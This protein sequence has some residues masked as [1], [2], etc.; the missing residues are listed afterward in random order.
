MMG[1]LTQYKKMKFAKRGQKW[2][3]LKDCG[4]FGVRI[5][6]IEFDPPKEVR[7]QSW[8]KIRVTNIVCLPDLLNN[9][10]FQVA[11]REGP[12]I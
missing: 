11:N 2:L 12:Q 10:G 1:N 6:N 5:E 4:W 7:G 3:E 8:R 9:G